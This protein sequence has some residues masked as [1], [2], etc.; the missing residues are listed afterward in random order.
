MNVFCPPKMMRGVIVMIISYNCRRGVLVLVCLIKKKTAYEL[1]SSDWSS[2]GCSS[3]LKTPA[4]RASPGRRARR[5]EQMPHAVAFHDQR[6]VERTR[7]DR[8]DIVGERKSVV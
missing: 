7:R 3:D 1:R 8:L 6:Q 5:A 4:H 2:D